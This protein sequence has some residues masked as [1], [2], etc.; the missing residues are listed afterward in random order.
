MR[1]L[2]V[3][4]STG[5]SI[6]SFRK[7]DHSKRDFNIVKLG[8]ELTKEELHC[9]INFRVDNM[10]KSGLPEEVKMLVPYRELNA[11]HTVGY[12]ELFDHL[13]HKISL[14]EAVE[15]IKKHTRQYAKRQMTWFRKDKEIRWFS[16]GQIKEMIAFAEEKIRNGK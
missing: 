6:L 13:D 16:P 10:M 3:M 2:E 9:N 7:G 14:E 5:R 12:A 1:A 4:E 11:L 8:L 15:E